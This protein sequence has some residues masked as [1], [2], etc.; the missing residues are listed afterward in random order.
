MNLNTKQIIAIAAAV[1][2]VLAVSTVQLTDVFGAGPAKA[3]ASVCGLLNM[4]LT[5][6]LAAISGQGSL[7]RDVQSMEGVESIVV[8]KNAN[9]TLAG[10]A[11]DP[12]QTK[13]EVK[14]G[15]EAEVNATANS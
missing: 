12:L 4:I 13:V 7:V 1:I 6:V 2:S 8:N 9:S 11:I 5:S 14:P 15:A 10:L 3:I